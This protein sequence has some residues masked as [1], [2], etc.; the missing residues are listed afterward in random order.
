[1][2]GSFLMTGGLLD[3]LGFR[4]HAQNRSRRKIAPTGVVGLFFD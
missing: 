2:T 4:V 1:M 3:R